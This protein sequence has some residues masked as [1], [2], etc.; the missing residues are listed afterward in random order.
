MD[1]FIDRFGDMPKPTER[2]IRVAL[3]KAIATEVGVER[4]EWQGGNLIFVVKRPDLALWS[5]VFAKWKNMRFGPVGDRVIY[6]PDNA[7]V[8]SIASKIMKDYLDAYK[9]ESSEG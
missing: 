5:E 9:G 8:C 2:L 7:D 6:R 1:E 4:I 3:T